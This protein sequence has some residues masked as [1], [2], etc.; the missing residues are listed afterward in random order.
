MR[1]KWLLLSSASQSAGIYCQNK[2]LVA[3]VAVMTAVMV[4][5]VVVEIVKWLSGCVPLLGYWL[6]GCPWLSGWVVAGGCL[7]KWLPVVAWSS[8]C[9]QRVMQEH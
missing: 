2:I 3:A 5:N 7:V 6:S 8:G 4:V 9:P 1:P